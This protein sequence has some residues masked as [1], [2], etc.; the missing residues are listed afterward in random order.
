MLKLSEDTMIYVASCAVDCRKAINGLAA[1]VLEALDKQPHDGS[2]YVF[3][4]QAC[5]QDSIWVFE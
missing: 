2:V 5:R 1:L 4:N 3:Y